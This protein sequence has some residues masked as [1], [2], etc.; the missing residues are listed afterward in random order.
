MELKEEIFNRLDNADQPFETNLAYGIKLWKSNSFYYM[1][2]YEV[3]FEFF[4]DRVAGFG[5]QLS[6]LPVDE[7]DSK[8]QIVNE[9]LAL[10]CP[11]NA[12]P[13]R[14]I[15]KL[16]EAFGEVNGRTDSRVLLESYLIVTFDVKYKHFYK[17]NYKS[18]GQT[19]E[20]A[21]NYY[22]KFLKGN[23]DKDR[24]EET[25]KRILD[26]I[27]IYV[28]SAGDGE[29][30]QNA[31]TV[32]LT[33]VCNVIL[34]LKA[35][36]LDR[37]EDL[38]QLLKEVYFQEGQSSKYNRVV[39]QSKK[40]LLMGYFDP[41]QLPVHV[42]ALLIE[43]YL[44]AY[45]DVKLDV[46][47][48]L[49]YILLH[50]FVDP[51]KSV[52]SEA[53][54]V[55]QLTKY[56]FHLLKKYF[57]KIDQ[58]LVQD[59]DFTG[60]FTIKL[61][62]FLEKYDSS[63]EHLRDLFSLICTINEYNPLILETSIIDI[64]LRTMFIKKGPETLEKFQSMLISTIGLYVRLNRTENF[65]EE[66]FMKL[67]D[68]LDD[69]DLGD[70]LKELR[71]GSRKRKS[72]AVVD[73]TPSKRK[74][75][76]SGH[77]DVRTE[78]LDNEYYLK[79]L[80]PADSDDFSRKVLRLQLQD[81]WK[82]IA[83]AWP[84]HN[85]RLNQSMM[86]YVKGLL[87]KRSFTYW[88]KMQDYLGDL[89]ETLV[90]DQQSETELFKVEF[91]TCWMCYFFAGNTLIEQTNL[92]WEKLGKH[93]AEFDELLAKFGRLLINE[94]LTDTRLFE[95]FL[96]L[97]YF[98]ENYRLV[99]HYYRP[100]SIEDS[101][102]DQVHQFLT[103]EEWKVLEHRIPSSGVVLMNRIHLQKIRGHQMNGESPDDQSDLVEKILAP[104]SFEQLRWVLMDRSSNCWFMQLLSLDQKV[105]VVDR[106]L[107]NGCYTEIEY[108][109]EQLSDDHNLMEV[110]LISTYKRIVET[111]LAECKS[112]VA[113]KLSFDG[114]YEFDEETVM[115]KI[116][117]LLDKKAEKKGES[118]SLAN[119]NDLKDLL[120]ILNSIRI[121]EL[122][123][124]Q[125]TIIVSVGI[126]VFTD[127]MDCGDPD[128]V[129]L[130]GSVINKQ[131]TFGTVPNLLKFLNIDT[132]ITI[133]GQSSPVIVAFVR[134]T[135]SYLTSEA[136]DSLRTTLANFLEQSDERFE[137]LLT[138]FF[139]L[140]KSNA[141]RL[142]LIPADQVSELLTEYVAAIEAFIGGK[143]AKKV[144]KS[145]AALFD[146]LLKGC[147]LIIHYKATN[148]KE[149][150]EELREVFLQF[151]D[152]ALKVDS[153]SSSTLLTN[154]LQ[155]K[156]FLKL[157]PERIDQVVENRW[158]S[159]LSQMRA[160]CTTDSGS[161]ATDES[162]VDAAH[163]QSKNVK[164]FASFLTH[165]QSATKLAKRFEQ[166][167]KEA[168]SDR[169]YHTKRFVLRVYS[170]FAKNAFASG[171][172]QEVEKV[173]VRSFGKVVADEILPLCVMK[174]FFDDRSCLEDILSCFAAVVSNP[175]LTLV[176]SVMD[177]MLEFLS[178][179]NIKKYTVKDGEEKAF[180][181][182]HR[183]ISD[184]LY[185][186]MI[187]RP[188][189]VAHR[190]PQFFFV[191][192]GLI[193][194]VITYK[195]DRP[196][197]K[198]LNSFEILTLS[199]LL[200]PME[201]IMSHAE[202]KIA[203]DL[204]IMAPYVLAQII[205]FIIQSKRPATLH[206]KVSQTVYNV[207]YGLIEMYDKH[208]A[209]YLLRTC[210]EASKNVYTE[211]VKGFRKYRSFKGKI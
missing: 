105:T 69:H 206:E 182:L 162:D 168:T 203:K 50:V 120:K 45:R 14:L 156:D 197:E 201:K 192:N 91:A 18:Y 74:R 26:D 24:E 160:E 177:H 137:L 167:E 15:P 101:L 171:V 110:V 81:Q 193:A 166:L 98:Y 11:S 39:D 85:G 71:K 122:A 10:P 83:F 7:F 88:R 84:D 44:K 42:I 52:L 181:Q 135:V 59:F 179:I 108:A 80:Y 127:V 176:P 2:K 48:F 195:E 46:L 129:A 55:F 58:K 143:S 126:L 37:Q 150:T 198:P 29:S 144:R 17:F 130:H 119:T 49:K 210:D 94:T 1:S 56:V 13:Q 165:H 121:D 40:H 196:L 123:E 138:I 34:T 180:Y 149:L 136:F 51:E 131:L 75:T 207:C 109:I 157:D 53:H 185:L 141:N 134:Q 73:E 79:L 41:K 205:H 6:G 82:S 86:D 30:W 3:I 63:E 35:H 187:I 67:G 153:L 174:K 145:D 31:F 5:R 146:H 169:S 173:F 158:T 159:F 190:L 89:L 140:Q 72:M 107:Q 54:Q 65:R 22:G 111:I 125:K 112:S 152:Q 209:S 163:M 164:V 116:R 202:K 68:Y 200:L 23:F 76:E 161:T 20:L 113:R 128:L 12:L 139:Y 60:I 151:V 184:V 106:L 19:L 191:F 95:S 124:T 175:K 38:L 62:E 87:T 9:F 99:V 96:K 97:V 208:S 178:S 100:D 155:H 32:A 147:S 211:I 47:L 57:I 61:K 28:K 183:L 4:V 77:D 43:G 90:E 115:K 78:L 117:K 104:G 102:N 170:I 189:Y 25:I 133:F 199:D 186:M 103:E 142:K 132:L 27:R 8:W 172:K 33:S 204:R 21:L 148:K 70:Q 154:A 118:V 92:F 188:N 64:I 114:V 93:F 66:L 16:R 194:S 36:G